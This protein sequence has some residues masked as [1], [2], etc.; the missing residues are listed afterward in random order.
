MEVPFG[1]G[2]GHEIPDIEALMG[3]PRAGNVVVLF[4]ADGREPVYAQIEVTAAGVA[5]IAIPG[6]LAAGVSAALALAD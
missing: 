3:P 6:Y 1:E 5:I 2:V 4:Y